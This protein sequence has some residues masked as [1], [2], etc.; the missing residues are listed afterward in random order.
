MLRVVTWPVRLVRS[1]PFTSLF[2]CVF[3]VVAP[4]YYRQEQ[5]INKAESAA[6]RAE[7]ANALL[8]EQRTEGRR[9]A[10][11]KDKRFALGHNALVE[12]HNEF[13][14][15]LVTGGG[16]RK[17]NPQTQALVDAEVARNNRNIVSVP[18]C[19]P[20]GLALLPGEP[21]DTDQPPPQG[22]NP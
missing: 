12:S 13:V 22:D 16:T 15:I 21:D 2:V 9:L 17:L 10:C 8:I 4:G 11:E 19:S 6:V 14:L 5:A 7:E 18:D 20:E 3:L 1:H